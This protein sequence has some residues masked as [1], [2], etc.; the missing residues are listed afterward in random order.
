MQPPLRHRNGIPFFDDKT[1]ADFKG[2]V[3][4]RY[5]EM[6]TKQTAL[7]L[8]DD[9]WNGYPMQNS[10][11]FLESH[12]SIP[13]SAHVVELGCSVGRIIGTIAEAHPDFSCWAIDYSYQ[14]LKRAKEYWIDGKTIQLDA[15]IKGAKKI[16]LNGKTL[17]NLQLGLA[18]AESLPFDTASQD[19]VISSFLFDRL[20]DPRKGLEEMNRILRP[21]GQVMMI[22][23]LNYTKSKHWDLYYPGE[24]IQNLMAEIGFNIGVWEE[25]H[26]I[27]EPLDVH[28]NVVLWKCLAVVCFKQVSI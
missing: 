18:R 28:G 21:G 25:N 12:I 11:D 8:A 13:N 16:L 9:I 15:S 23:P 4:E 22:S 6:V 5:D 26:M 3:Y 2:D 27:I 20:N 24:K 7:H 10:L 19:I 1:E 17:N 14:L